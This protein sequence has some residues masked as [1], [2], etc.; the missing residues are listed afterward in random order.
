MRRRKYGFLFAVLLLSLTSLSPSFDITPSGVRE[1]PGEALLPADPSPGLEKPD[2]GP[3]TVGVSMGEK[4]LAQLNQWN[5]QFMELNSIEVNI[6]NMEDWDEGSMTERLRLGEG[7]DILLLDSHY[8]KPLAIKGLLFPLE[9]VPS[10]IPESALPAG[11]LPLLQWNGYQ[12]GIPL[13]ADPYVMVYE[14]GKEPPEPAAYREQ[15]SPLFS[16]DPADPYAFAAAV[17]AAG[18][19]PEHP[20]E[21]ETAKLDIPS[22]S[23]L[24]LQESTEEY[25]KRIAEGSAEL[26]PL[27]IAA[28]SDVNQDWPE[29][30][31]VMLLAPD[32]SGFAPVIQSRS[33]ALTGGRETSS[34]ALTWVGA[35][36][37]AAAR[38]DEWLS[39]TGRY[40]LLSSGTVMDDSAITPLPAPLA[41]ESLETYLQQGASAQLTFGEPE[42]FPVYE[43]SIQQLLSE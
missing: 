1:L 22:F 3:I 26:A 29:G 16:I 34:T 27:R 32:N 43:S 20:G 39:V 37:Q 19:N 21:E 35:M 12:W 40:S 25:Q 28:A 8:I 36:T 18:G 30:Y 38:S 14:A 9:A 42:G 5:E 4:E 10:G 17:F 23:K 41:F 33:F 7:P 15:R 31:E 13:D 6:E 24:L 2:P 11:L